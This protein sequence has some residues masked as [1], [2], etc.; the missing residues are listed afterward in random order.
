V[1]ECEKFVTFVCFL[2]VLAAAGYASY[3]WLAPMLFN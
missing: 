3:N 1:S 2:A